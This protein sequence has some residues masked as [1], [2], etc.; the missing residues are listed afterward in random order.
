VE[1]EWERF[2]DQVLR[3]MEISA[4][5]RDPKLGALNAE[6][7]PAFLSGAEMMVPDWMDLRTGT[8]TRDVLIPVAVD[9]VQAGGRWDVKLLL[10]PPPGP[11]DG[12][13]I[14]VRR[15]RSASMR[16]VR[17]MGRLLSP[18]VNETTTAWV[19][20]SGRVTAA[21]WY[22]GWIGA[23]AGTQKAWQPLGEWRDDG[24]E[25]AAA[26]VALGVALA[27]R[28]YWTV[29]LGWADKP[30][31]VFPTDSVGAAEVFRLRD[32]PNGAKRRAALLHWVC[33]H[34]R[35]GRGGRQHAVGA[36]LRGA[37]QFVWNGLRCEIV[38][39]KNDALL[40]VG[41]RHEEE[42]EKPPTFR[43][44]LRRAWGELTN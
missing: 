33:E 37:Q 7:G 5:G 12:T 26:C 11:D 3:F 30:Q 24:A 22:Q 32:V 6:V 31:V 18:H 39:S 40:T 1:R 8:R 27:A 42:A 21:R 23:G 28:T 19:H 44:R 4:F 17:G 36:H 41:K 15:F 16:D 2:T 14:H 38:P 35:R 10:G 43:E 20:R 25:S 13:L 34:S 29:A 9:P